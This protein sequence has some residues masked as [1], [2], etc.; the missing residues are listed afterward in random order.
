MSQ[1]LFICEDERAQAVNLQQI[2][3]NF[4]LFHGLGQAEIELT[5]TPAE[6]MACCQSQQPHAGIYLLDFN[7]HD[8]LD[9][10]DLAGWIRQQDAL[11]KIIFVTSYQE[12][13][14][15]ILARQIEPLAYIA[16]DL[17]FED[18]QSKVMAAIDLAVTRIAAEQ[19]AQQTNFSFSIGSQIFNLNL[20]DVI[21]LETSMIPHHLALIFNHGQTDFCGK[22]NDFAFAYP[23]L[24]QVNRSLLVNPD[25][26]KQV[27]LARRRLWLTGSLERQIA[28]GRVAAVK[29]CFD[30]HGPQSPK[31]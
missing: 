4:F 29:R 18:F 6:L 15:A 2:A 20:T 24:L 26:V 17:P 23:Q 19:Q 9:G 31:R 13:A 5:T 14:P 30:V 22:I 8:R 1:C 28:H 11:A 7:L 16:K 21:L 25:H 12:L 3:R 10:L 27:D